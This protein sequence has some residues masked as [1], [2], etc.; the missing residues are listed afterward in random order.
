MKEARIEIIGHDGEVDQ[1][2]LDAM[3]RN[4]RELLNQGF[5]HDTSITIGNC[6][7]GVFSKDVEVAMS[8]APIEGQDAATTDQEASD[9]LTKSF[10]DLNK[11]EPMMTVLDAK[12]LAY[13]AYNRGRSIGELHC[14]LDFENWWVEFRKE[15]GFG[16]EQPETTPSESVFEGIMSELKDIARE[17]LGWTDFENGTVPSDSLYG[18]FW[19]AI[20]I[21]LHYAPIHET[22]KG[23]GNQIEYLES[24][25]NNII[26]S[27]EGQS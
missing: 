18:Q 15:S 7:F 10:Q 27:R 17:S 24:I 4:I 9:R 6:S 13:L 5:H 14:T 22:T 26:Q 2:V 8:T 12:T 11:N 23:D 20:H 25:A 19:K 21:R 1:K 3:A 16:N